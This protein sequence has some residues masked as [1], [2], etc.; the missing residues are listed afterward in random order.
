MLSAV[1][2]YA[3]IAMLIILEFSSRIP[4]IYRQLFLYFNQRVSYDGWHRK[5]INLTE[6]E[7]VDMERYFHMRPL[8][9]NIQLTWHLKSMWKTLCARVKRSNNSGHFLKQWNIIDYFFVLS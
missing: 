9:A 4:L 2:N 6:Q 1:T 3:V 8:S 7:I 5:D